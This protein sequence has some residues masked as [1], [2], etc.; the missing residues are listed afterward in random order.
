[1]SSNRVVLHHFRVHFYY[2]SKPIISFTESLDWIC[3]LYLCIEL[4]PRLYFFFQ[5]QS[6]YHIELLLN[7]I[8]LIKLNRIKAMKTEV[9]EPQYH[10][11]YYQQILQQNLCL[12]VCVVSNWFHLQIPWGTIYGEQPWNGCH[13]LII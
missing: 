1:M 8:Y 11:Q 6:H 5:I 9:L 3:T 4:S 2:S 7:I 10:S 12:A 13:N